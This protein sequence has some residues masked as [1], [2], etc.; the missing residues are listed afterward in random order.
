MTALDF[1]GDVLTGLGVVV[2]VYHGA[3]L[4]AELRRRHCPAADAP[5]EPPRNVRVVKADGTV[6]PV[7]CVYR[8]RDEDGLD[9]WVSVRPIRFTPWDGDT[10]A[11]DML[12]GRSA[13]QILAVSD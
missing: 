11:C 3:R 2:L 5:P 6:I 1:L 9:L 13:V 8:G 7:E 12:P 4:A 10:I